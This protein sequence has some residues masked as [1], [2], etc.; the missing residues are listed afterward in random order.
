L[1]FLQTNIPFLLAI[2]LTVTLASCSMDKKL[3]SSGYHIEW[4]N[5]MPV[6][7]KTVSASQNKKECVQ[8]IPEKTETSLANQPETEAET[9]LVA[10]TEKSSIQISDVKTSFIFKGKDAEQLNP[11]IKLK[12][13][14]RNAELK[15]HNKISGKFLYIL[16]MCILVVGLFLLLYFFAFPGMTVLGKVGYSILTIGLLALGFW[17]KFKLSGG[18]VFQ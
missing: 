11:S 1:K 10:S 6:P 18:A 3:Y 5:R 17:I 4:K 15:P 2:V 13:L 8:S 7:E 14:T 12:T 16:V 9:E